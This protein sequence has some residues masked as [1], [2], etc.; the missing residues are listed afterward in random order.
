MLAFAMADTRSASGPGYDRIRD[1]LSRRFLLLRSSWLGGHDSGA[2]HAGVVCRRPGLERNTI[3]CTAV[4]HLFE[5]RQ[6][7]GSL[8]TIT[9]LGLDGSTRCSAMENAQSSRLRRP[10]VVLAVF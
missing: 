8:D 6:G 10:S 5:E 1:L 7:S 9:L 2:K 3:Q 4:Q